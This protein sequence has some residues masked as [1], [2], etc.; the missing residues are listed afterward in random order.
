MSIE[1]T[2]IKELKELLWQASQ[3]NGMLR[4]LMAEK[5]P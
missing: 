1:N 2:D 5:K 4:R 3:E